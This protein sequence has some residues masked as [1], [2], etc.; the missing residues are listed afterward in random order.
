M[1]AGAAPK[2]K[3]RGREH[4]FL[5]ERVVRENDLTT[6]QD[7]DRPRMSNEFLDT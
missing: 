2:P 4:S 3:W 1:Y 6:L 7:L 5:I